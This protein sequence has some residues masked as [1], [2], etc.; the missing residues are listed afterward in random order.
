VDVK[1]S[2]SRCLT[3]LCKDIGWTICIHY[4]VLPNLVAV[5]EMVF[6]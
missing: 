5:D 6:A 3:P 1:E 4:L 2:L